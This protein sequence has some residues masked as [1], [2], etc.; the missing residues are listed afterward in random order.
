MPAVFAHDMYG[1]SVYRGLSAE[2]K[3]LIRRERDCFYLGLQG[4]DL[5]FF[6]RPVNRN[7]IRR[8]GTRIHMD[9][10][11][12]FF[13][14]CVKRERDLR[15]LGHE[16]EARSLAAYL[17]GIACHY[18][19]D[20]SLHDYINYQDRNSPYSHTAL[21]TELDRRLLIREGY[22]P[23]AT[24][25]DSHLKNTKTTRNAARQTFGESAWTVGE[26][27]WMMKLTNWLFVNSDE[28][29]KA[30]SC[31]L[32]RWVRDGRLAQGMFMRKKPER[33]CEELVNSMERQFHESV[34]TG[35]DLVNALW[36]SMETG[37]GLP[38]RF[39]KA[40]S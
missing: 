2:K 19:L 16:R 39:E 28:P 18:A 6:Y 29:V 20:S 22:R 34:R 25:R 31:R 36:E 7:R 24:R 21:E 8:K 15:E 26:S 3:R 14:R 11:A 32:L 38:E 10:A 9:S 12:P 35:I 37:N 27:I 33:G 30:L 40:F 5:L 13:D 4:P 23:L 1:R 17:I